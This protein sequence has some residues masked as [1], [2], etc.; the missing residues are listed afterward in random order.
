MLNRAAASIALAAAVACGIAAAAPA[1]A[2]DPPPRSRTTVPV[3]ISSDVATGL[4][5]G[6]RGGPSDIDDG[7]AVGMALGLP[8]VEVR[9]VVVTL[10]NNN[11]QPELVVAR[12]VVGDLLHR[13]DVPVVAGSSQRLTDPAVTWFDGQPLPA[14]C[15]NEGVRF[16]AEQLRRRRLTIL[17]IGPLT[18]IACLALNDPRDAANIVEVVAIMG[19]RPGEEFE[20]KGKTGL[21]DF[22][23]VMDE[24]AAGVLLASK[25]PLT[26]LTFDLTKSAL[27]PRSAVEALQHRSSP[28]AKFFYQAAQPWLDFWKKAFAEDGFH[29]WDQNAIYYAANPAAFACTGAAATVVACEGAPYHDASPNHCP[30]HG[31]GQKHSLDKEASQLWLDPAGTPQRVKVCTAYASAASKASFLDSLLTFIP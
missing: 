27:V 2:A 26:F 21:T 10:G 17:A 7:F 9:G 22:N 19:R 16:M 23:Y 6:W 4:V 3:I 20:L 24:R 1:R 15:V 12:R 31:P 25:V 5:G 8:A 30:G 13:Q 14:E 29:P 28:A 11:L 18:D